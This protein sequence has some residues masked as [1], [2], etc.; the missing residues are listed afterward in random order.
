MSCERRRVVITG[1]GSITPI[2]NTLE[3]YWDSMING[4]SGG[5]TITYFDPEEYP[6]KIACEVKDF[7]YEPYISKKEAR[8][9]DPF[10]IYAISATQMAYEQSGINADE[11]D[12]DRA[13]VLIGSG[14][15]GIQILTDELKVLFERGP[16]RISPFLIPMMIAN[17]AS[18]LVAIRYGFKGPNETVVTACATST[19]AVGDGFRLIQEDHADVMIV[20][21]AEAAV[22]PIALAGFGSMRALSTRNDEPEKASRPF[23]KDRD[24]FVI[25]EGA[26]I[27]MLEELEHAKSRGAE[28]IAEICG[29]GMSADAYHMTAPAP[30][31]EGAIR[32]MK[33]A[34][35]DAE[36]KVDE[37][38]HINAHGTSTELNDKN[39]TEAI[40]AL[41]GK[42]AYDIP[43]T[44]TKSMVG[45]LLGAAG[46]LE[47]IA[48]ILTIKN[49]IIP[50]TINY[51]TKDPDCD[52]D[53]TP[54][55][56]REQNI[57]NAISNSFGFG[58]Q[59][60]TLTFKK[61]ED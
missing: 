14:I 27:L 37:I 31:G 47:A 15:G 18:G 19:H 3:E 49:S 25:G 39:E 32:S 43:I 1:M 2:G 11:I 35:E 41:F 55:E 29:Y 30:G 57:S 17:M 60:A 59:N 44:A 4:V 48:T 23:D 52:L 6:S 21:G 45:H 13:G 36:L 56:A 54:N 24:G 5:G 28:I 58:G 51:E 8:R 12:L 53:Y 20:G 10:I 7:D 9:M 38:E 46:A 22:T 16:G 33:L 34:I 50:P 61:Y 42:R 26:G 40:K